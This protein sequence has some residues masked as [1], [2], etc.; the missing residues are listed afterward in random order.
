MKKFINICIAVL[1]LVATPLI[2]TGCASSG[3]SEGSS[4]I[5]IAEN[6]LE[7]IFKT[8]LTLAANIIASDGTQQLAI[9]A[10]ESYLT[11]VVTNEEQLATITQIIESAIPTLADNVSSLA[12]NVSSSLNQTQAKSLTKKAKAEFVTKNYVQSAEFQK[13]VKDCLAKYNNK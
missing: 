12:D 13:L 3:T 7:S 10:I 4:I 11:S 1:L 2:F 9:S 5:S 6:T 8:A